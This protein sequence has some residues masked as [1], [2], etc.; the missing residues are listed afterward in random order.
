GT[1]WVRWSPDGKQLAVVRGLLEVVTLKT[2]RRE[3]VG[4]GFLCAAWLPDL[5]RLDA[6]DPAAGLAGVKA[7]SPARGVSIIAL[8]F[9]RRA[10][11]EKYPFGTLALN[12]RGMVTTLSANGEVVL[13]RPFHI[14][15]FHSV[16]DGDMI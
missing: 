4:D 6:P 10:D 1:G 11:D 15:D 3:V 14:Y 8:P 16:E 7:F 9:V 13:S 5:R 12:T 2:G